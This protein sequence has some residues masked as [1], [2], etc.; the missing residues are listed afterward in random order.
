M[1]K[2]TRFHKMAG[3]TYYITALC[4]SGVDFDL[5][6]VS[7]PR[8]RS[9]WHYY[10]HDILSNNRGW[11][12][13]FKSSGPFMLDFPLA[14]DQVERPIDE[15]GKAIRTNEDPVGWMFNRIEGFSYP[16]N[17]SYTVTEEY[18]QK[19]AFAQ[20]SLYGLQRPLSHST[21]NPPWRSAVDTSSRIAHSISDLVRL[22]REIG[23]DLTH[24]IPN[25]AT[26]RSV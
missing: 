26:L 19:T 18:R 13:Q 23:L 7:Y 22:A 14:V 16:A 15:D 8:Y 3:S 20:L 9:P 1:S 5:F 12:I 4:T 10:D 17:A 24:F 6:E 2:T 11:R 21:S 25:V